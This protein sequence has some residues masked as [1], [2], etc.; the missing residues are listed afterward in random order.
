L[1]GKGKRIGRVKG[2][3]TIENFSAVVDFCKKKVVIIL[4]I[5]NNVVILQT[6]WGEGYFLEVSL[7]LYKKHIEKTHT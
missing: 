2:I 5:R 4:S 3:K 1:K 6:E 7:L